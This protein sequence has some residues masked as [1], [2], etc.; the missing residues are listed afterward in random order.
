MKDILRD[1]IVKIFKKT[2]I[3]LS[4]EVEIDLPSKK[5]YGDYSTNIPLKLSKQLNKP[6]L[7]IAQEI[8]ENF[9]SLPKIKKIEVV[10]PGFINFYIDEGIT[11]IDI[12]E[13]AID[14]KFYPV[15][16]HNKKVIIEH[17]SVNPNKA[18]H[19][20]HLR[21]AVLGDVLAN[22]YR[23]LG[24]SVEVQNY[25][26]DTGLQ[27]A[28]TTNAILNLNIEQKEGQAFDDYCWDLYTEINKQ[29]EINSKLV[30][31]RVKIS[32]LI[33]EGKNEIADLSTNIV[34]K[35]VNCHLELMSK[36]N[37]YYDLLV[38]ESDVIAF[39]F[40]EQAFEQL[41]HS[42]NFYLE[43]EG[44][45][46]GCWVLKYDS[47]NFGNKIFVRSNGTKVYTAK[48]TAYHLWKFGL[49]GKDF[50]YSSWPNKFN[51]HGV[52]KTDVAGTDSANYG[53]G[54]I[55]VN[56]IDE[57]QTYPQEMVKHALRSIGYKEQYNNYHHLAYGVVNLSPNTAKTLGLDISDGKSTYAMSGRK[58]VGVKV[59]QLLDLMS[60]HLDKARHNQ[61]QESEK[62]VK[63]VDTLDIAI[64]ALKH[65]MLKNNPISP[66][67]FDYEEALRLSGNTGPYLQ[68]SY[69]RASSI[70]NKAD[71]IS[72]EFI[73]VSSN[74][75]E[76]ERELIMLIGQWGQVIQD[77]VNNNST[78]LIADYAFRLS[79]A[80]HSFY[81]KNN[82]LK[83][84]PDTKRFRLIVIR[85][86]KNVIKDVLDVMGI[87]APEQM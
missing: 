15:N 57:R 26:D 81:E 14:K 19:V 10:K 69:T 21:N 65:Y 67:T 84:E 24:Y 60:S 86:Y 39:G 54:D 87:M 44:N 59:T 33:E 28:D 63:R 3:D 79:S 51:E 47:S 30:E 80:F 68:Y 16:A 22:I 11:F 18:M 6:P 76:S 25:I 23:K 48:D 34:N 55:L 7:A 66:V 61:E 13:K 37:I 73:T 75:T 35:I 46:A 12:L 83:S 1:E 38:Y 40:W 36:F 29:Y 41:K 45:Q 72:P 42:E 58:G 17:T 49:L 64:G 43:T 50:K 77:T 27:V 78:S 8:V 74:L 2:G 85:A 62:D 20:G 4:K 71:D 70:L 56:V 53:K 52:S 82:V 31:E 9:P 5:E 32:K